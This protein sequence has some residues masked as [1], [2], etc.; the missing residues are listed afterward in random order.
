MSHI[1]ISYAREDEVFTNRIA[2]ALVNKGLGVWIDLRNLQAGIEFEGQIVAA[3]T[4]ADALLFLFSANSAN[5]P[6]C[7]KEINEA[8]EHNKRIIVVRIDE[9][10]ENKL[11]PPL[12]P[13]KHFVVYREG[14]D[15][16]D[17]VITKIKKGIDEDYDWI[18]YHT[19]LEVKAADWERTKDSGRL[20][21]G[22]ELREAVGQLITV[23]SHKD[24]LP[25]DRQSRFF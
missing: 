15:D 3:I 17:S 1:F 9:V 10:D 5:A 19:K 18:Q 12:S 25:T 8:I 7:E 20:L 6:G 2:D 21:R 13:R 23:G 14:K 11:P 24:P 4:E 16:F 22:K